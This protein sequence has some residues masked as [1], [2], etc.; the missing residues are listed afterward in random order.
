MSITNFWESTT[1]CCIKHDTPVD[2]EITN[3]S[4]G[5][6]YECPECHSKVSIYDFE[7]MLNHFQNLIVK[8]YS[9]GEEPD[10]T[11]STWTQKKNF[12]KVLSYKDEKMRV[13]ANLNE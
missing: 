9:I 6:Y 8:A 1:I 5:P 3:H 10:I 7:K 13:G 2:L 11:N 12:Y 4:K